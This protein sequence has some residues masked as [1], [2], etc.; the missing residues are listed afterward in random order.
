MTHPFGL[1]V[2]D[3][4]KPTGIRTASP[5]AAGC[6]AYRVIHQTLEF[7]G[8]CHLNTS[9]KWRLLRGLRAIKKVIQS[10]RS[11]QPGIPLH[12]PGKNVWWN[13]KKKK[14]SCLAGDCKSPLKKIK[15]VDSLNY[16]GH[17]ISL[18]KVRPQKVQIRKNQ[19][20][21]L[22][23]F[24]KLLGDINWLWLPI[25]LATQDLINLFQIYY[26]VIEI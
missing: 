10:M 5:R 17:R 13:L 6:S 11:L 23:D 1:I 8:S 24:Q 3:N 22:N 15:R 18:Q 2:Y 12:S 7:S 20:R 26:K 4:W 25:G 21:T 19:L 14:K 16:L 9:G